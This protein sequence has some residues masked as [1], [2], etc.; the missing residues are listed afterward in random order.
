MEVVAA[1]AIKILVPN[2]TGNLG[3]QVAAQ[4]GD[5]AV[6]V[7]QGMSS[8]RR[9]LPYK[10]ADSIAIGTSFGCG[11]LVVRRGPSRNRN[12]EHGLKILFIDRVVQPCI[13]RKKLFQQPFDLRRCHGFRMAAEHQAD[14]A[15]EYASGHM[16]HREA[17]VA[18]CSNR[19]ASL[20]L[21]Q[22]V[23][24]EFCR[25]ATRIFCANVA[26]NAGRSRVEPDAS[27]GTG[28]SWF[29]VAPAGR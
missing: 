22:A 1:S 10:P 14:S 25:K 6:L 20:S 17:Q 27:T 8:P 9:L 13:I 23:T 3:K 21:S 7:A 28:A 12:G 2:D 11:A 4:S 18:S 5:H 15:A 26:A 29:G 16:R 19:S 24:I